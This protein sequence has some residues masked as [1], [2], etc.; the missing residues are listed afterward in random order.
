MSG[1]AF[2]AMKLF[3]VDP[4]RRSSADIAISFDGLAPDLAGSPR[5]NPEL[6][7][8]SYLACHPTIAE[9]SCVR[10][11]VRARNI[12][13][14][15][16]MNEISR[17]FPRHVERNR[18]PQA[19]LV[20]AN[21]RIVTA[22][23]IFSGTVHVV[24]GV[25]AALGRGATRLSSAYDVEGDYILP[26]LVDVHTDHLEKQAMP[27][28]GMFWNAIN[29]AVT[30]DIVLCAAGTTTVFDSLIL[31]AVG[32]PDRRK[33]LPIMIDGLRQARERGL[34]RIDHLLHLRCDAR[35]EDLIELLPPYLDDARLRFVTIMDDG[36][37]RDADRFRRL[38]R[39]KGVPDEIIDREIAAT[40]AGGDCTHEN[41]QRLVELCRN[42]QLPFA[43]HD[44]TL[45]THITEAVAFGLKISEF[46]I[47]LE[48]ARAARAS[49]MTIIAG[50]PNIVAG[51]SHIGNVSG[52]TLAAEGLIDIVCSDYVPA[53]LLHALWTLAAAR[54]G[55][56]LAE[57]VA[58]GS[59]R[60]AEQFALLDRGE[61]SCGKRAD[62]VRVTEHHGMPVVRNVWARGQAVL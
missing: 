29:A 57:A 14:Q 7:H 8:L 1:L 49:G 30:H 54:D 26:V 12:G 45:A 18:P 24:N 47:T 25:I 39:R 50:A 16:E 61:L 35:E 31:G 19:E 58:M 51:R 4:C 13:T 48:A 33:L 2:P 38:E 52:R 59:K 20:I 6:L 56:T 44:D 3:F 5:T 53:S 37:R 36:P 15:D 55:P 22:T 21:A 43:S 34:L 46:P 9:P 41:R 42:R 23:E 62:L 28:A 32:N 11:S 17:S 10:H 60:P 40:A 27:R